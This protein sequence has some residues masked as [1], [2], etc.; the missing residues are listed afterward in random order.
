MNPFEGDVLN[1]FN[2]EYEDNPAWRWWNQLWTPK[3]R[4]KILFPGGPKQWV[5]S[6]S[7]S[8]RYHEPAEKEQ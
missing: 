8:G 5:I 2:I 1:A 7:A 3:R 6:W 4:V